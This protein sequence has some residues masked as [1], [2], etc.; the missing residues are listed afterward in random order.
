MCITLSNRPLRNSA[1]SIISGRFV[2][3]ITITPDMIEYYN[4]LEGLLTSGLESIRRNNDTLMG[5]ESV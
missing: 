2:A 3:A 1:G 4:K 5:I